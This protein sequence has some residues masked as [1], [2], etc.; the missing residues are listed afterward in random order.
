MS[1]MELRVTDQE[2]EVTVPVTL[3]S[4][5]QNVYTCRFTFDDSWDGY[6]KPAVFLRRAVTSGAY[7]ITNTAVNIP[8]S[9]LSDVDAVDNALK[10]GVYGVKGS[11]R[12]PTVY[13]PWLTVEK[14]RARPG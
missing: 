3:V 4:G 14:A 12:K 2:I 9:A 7:V 11:V 6:D 10:I 5:S 1:T 13:T 8:A